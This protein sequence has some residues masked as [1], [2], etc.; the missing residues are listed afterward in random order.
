MGVGHASLGY[1][2]KWTI[3]K[4]LTGLLVRDGAISGYFLEIFAIFII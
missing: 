2:F 1:T 3:S 4:G